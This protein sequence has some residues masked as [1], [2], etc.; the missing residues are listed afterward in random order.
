LLNEPWG[1]EKRS[2]APLYR[3]AA[4]VIRS[5]DP[6][7]ILFLEGHITTNCGLQSRL[8]CPTFD[9]IVYAPHYYLP[10]MIVFGKWTGQTWAIRH[11]FANMR[12]KTQNWNA[13]LILGEFGAPANATRAAEYVDYVYDLLDDSLASG[14]Q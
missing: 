6:T 11:A 8:P 9:N 4:T 1:D 10:S 14:I 2:L 7:A 5:V 12:A 3:D 13:P